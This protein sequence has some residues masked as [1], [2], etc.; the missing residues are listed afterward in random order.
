MIAKRNNSTRGIIPTVDPPEPLVGGF[1]ALPSFRVHLLAGMSL[2]HAELRFQHRFGLRLLECRI[3]GVI[4]PDGALSLKQICGETDIEK[5]HASRLVT[6]L[7]E[8]DLVEKVGDA[9]DLRAIS[10]RLTPAGTDMYHAIYQDAVDR[11]R[12]WAAALTDDETR[13]LGTALEK[14]IDETRRMTAEELKPSS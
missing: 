3:I 9:T 11:N 4:G 1:R 10:V 7:I 5:A 6:R 8:R 12:R 2:R 13:V 14:L